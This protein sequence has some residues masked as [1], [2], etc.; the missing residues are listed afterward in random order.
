MVDNS[1]VITIVF[2][3]PTIAL[4]KGVVLKETS[5]LVYMLVDGKYYAYVKSE[6]N[7]NK[8]VY[9]NQR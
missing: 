6:D 9:L 8:I 5:K 7:A 2:N 1:N 3:N 4:K